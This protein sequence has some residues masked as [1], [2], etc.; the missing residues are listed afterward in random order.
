MK[1]CVNCMRKEKIA[2]IG[3]KDSILAFKAIGIE[4]F[5]TNTDDEARET[6][7]LLAR[8]YAVIF[9]TEDIAGRINDIVSRYKTRPYPAVI[10]IP[11]SEG[12]NGFGMNSSRKDVEK[13]IGADILFG[14][15]DK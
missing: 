6:L 13:A 15:E 14:R 4:V 12:S 9:I 11:S 5:P 8:D 10:S 2:V 3:D 7:K 1:G